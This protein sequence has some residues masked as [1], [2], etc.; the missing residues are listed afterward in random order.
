MRKIKLNKDQE[1]RIKEAVNLTVNT[2]STNGNIAQAV[3]NTK[4]DAQRSGINTNKV[5]FA[6]PAEESTVFTKKQIKEM[7]TK[8]LIKSSK[9]ITKKELSEILSSKKNTIKE[10]V[11]NMLYDDLQN[12]GIAKLSDDIKRAKKQL[13]YSI[14][15]FFATASQK[16]YDMKDIN[17]IITMTGLEKFIPKSELNRREAEFKNKNKELKQ[18]NNIK[19]E[20]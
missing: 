4:R 10:D 11:D 5:G 7:R 6:I 8:N 16:G 9:P 17:Q 2:A 3:Q 20:V 14:N 15:N 1:Q 12:S 13:E 18:Q 19:P